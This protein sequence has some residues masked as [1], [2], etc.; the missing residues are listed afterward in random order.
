M[1][2]A[3]SM[4]DDLGQTM[5]VLGCGTDSIAGSASQRIFV[6]AAIAPGGGAILR[7]GRATIFLLR[8]CGEKIAARVAAQSWIAPDNIGPECKTAGK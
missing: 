1:V 2:V 8:N 7:Q 5:R 6:A 3:R 4:W